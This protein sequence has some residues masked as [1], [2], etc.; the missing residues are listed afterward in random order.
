MAT[1]H[2]HADA[3]RDRATRRRITF[4]VALAVFAQEST[5]NFYDAQVPP[6]LRDHIA[7][8]ALVGFVMGMDNLLGIFIQP[9]MGNRSDRTRTWWGRR[10][11]Y[12]AVG[13]PIAALLFILLPHVGGLAAAADRGDRSP[14][15]WS[16]TRSS[17]SARRWCPTS[18]RPSAAAAPTPRSRSPRPSPSSWRR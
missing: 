13:M 1:P 5:W 3:Q 14:S 18:S 4:L 12:L 16:R 7:S 15:R 2:D 6:L 8:A 10:I 17:R 11:P 9:W